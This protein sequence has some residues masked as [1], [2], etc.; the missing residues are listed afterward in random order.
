MSKNWLIRN[1]VA[2]VGVGYSEIGRRLER[3][4]GLLARDSAEAAISDAGLEVGQIDG[5]ATY[6]DMPVRGSTAGSRDGVEI[7]SVEYMIRDWAFRTLLRGIAKTD[8]WGSWRDL[9]LRP[10]TPSPLE[11]AITHSYGG[12]CICRAAA[13]TSGQVP[14]QSV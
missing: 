7:V 9:S 12:R 11:R 5:V 8:I 1:K 3:P 4:L 6:P 10:Q 13:T 14:K 2:I